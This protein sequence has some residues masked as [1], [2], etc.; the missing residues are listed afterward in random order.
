M[1]LA[2]PSADPSAAF[3][4]YLLWVEWGQRKEILIR[5]IQDALCDSTN[6]SQIPY[7]F[8]L[9]SYALVDEYVIKLSNEYIKICYRNG[10]KIH[11]FYDPKEAREFMASSSPNNMCIVYGNYPH[12][13]EALPS[14]SNILYRHPLYFA[15][16]AQYHQEIYDHCNPVWLNF[17][18]GINILTTEARLDRYS[19]LLLQLC[20]VAAP[21][22]KVIKYSGGWRD[23]TKNREHNKYICA[24]IN[25]LEVTE[26][27]MNNNNDFVL[28]LEDDFSFI[29][30]KEHIYS[31]LGHFFDFQKKNRTDFYV[32]FLSYSKWGLIE[33]CSGS[34]SSSNPSLLG[35]SKQWCTTS[36]GYILQRSTVSVIRDCHRESVAKMIA[37]ET[38]NIYCCDRYWCRFG[39]EQK[40][41]VF[42]RKLGFQYI[43]H[44]D[45]VNN[46][47]INFD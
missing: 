15:D 23:Y 31:S 43:T 36:S 40:L 47:N 9:F 13:S 26:K 24:S 11:A 38:P 44:S 29:D 5:K 37:G 8:S 27:F 10:W 12:S 6:F 42:R 1:S 34:S 3:K 16:I 17:D 46:T 25:H 39:Q 21:L 33:D 22:S 18:G 28:I 14:P 45:I 19:H 32:C 4:D 20:Q 41:L 35:Y 30:D 2:D 7:Y